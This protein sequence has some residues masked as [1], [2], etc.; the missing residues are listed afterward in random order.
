MWQRSRVVHYWAKHAGRFERSLRGGDMPF[1][2]SAPVT[3]AFWWGG[4]YHL[5]LTQ[6]T[7]WREATVTVGQ[8]I[9]DL[10]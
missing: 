10:K 5:A 8:I 6:T 9:Q 2:D 1:P 7:A 3:G 4:R